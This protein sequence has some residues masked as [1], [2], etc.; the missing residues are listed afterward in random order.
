ASTVAA[1]EFLI[2]PSAA[3]TSTHAQ[4]V[5]AAAYPL[6][7][8]LLL[9][10]LLWLVLSPGERS[11]P[12][13]AL[14]AFVGSLLVLDVLNAAV[15]LARPGT[16]MHFLDAWYGLGYALLVFAALHPDVDELTRAGRRADRRLHPA[17]VMFLGTTLF[18]AP[19]IAIAYEPRSLPARVFLLASSVALG[20]IVLTRFAIA[21]RQRESAQDELA[22][23]APH[24]TLTQLVN[25]PLLLDRIA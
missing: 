12:T 24:D 17:R 22:F 19:A 7:D 18:T 2:A 14:C 1:W 20:A 21:A 5:V 15:P 11:A 13:R 3:G 6:G 16:S 4:V 10:A 25:R 23:K 8:V 9:A